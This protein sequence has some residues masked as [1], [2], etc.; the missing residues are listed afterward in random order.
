[1]LR[2][3]FAEAENVA[4]RILYIKIEACPRF[5]LQRLEHPSPTHFQFVE[6]PPNARYGNVRIQVFVLLAVF[7]VG[8][9][10]RSTLEMDREAIPR[11]RRIERLIVEIQLEAE[12][13]TVVRNGTV[14]IV[15]EKLRS[16]PGEARSR[17]TCHCGRPI[18]QFDNWRYRNPSGADRIT[19]QMGC[20]D[21]YRPEKP[22]GCSFIDLPH[23]WS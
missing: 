23:P 14:K 18:P 3:G 19:Y 10:F 2:D 8:R 9:Q 15:D 1:M 13:V 20:Y 21:S 17:L 4:V 7:S 12:P 22:E 5:F 11:D 16:Y 6:Q